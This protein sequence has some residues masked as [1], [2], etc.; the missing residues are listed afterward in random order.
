MATTIRIELDS[1]GVRHA[2]LTSPEVRAMLKAKVDAVAGAARGNTTLEV[3]AT[4]GGGSRARGEVRLVGPAG[5]ATEAKHRV[6]GTA[7]GAAS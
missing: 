1:D 4:V 6:L 7:L 3:V 2:A 5:A